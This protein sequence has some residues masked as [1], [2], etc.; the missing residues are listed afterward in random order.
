M[1]VNVCVCVRTR[2]RRDTHTNE[3]E[4]ESLNE[5]ASE[6]ESVLRNET[7]EGLN[8]TRGV[9]GSLHPYFYVRILHLTECT[10]R[11]AC[12][13]SCARSPYCPL[14]QQVLSEGS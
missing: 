5:R 1:P 11:I 3:E 7:E 13:A 6:R 8:E 14:A 10:R 4:G 2:M 9:P 12:N